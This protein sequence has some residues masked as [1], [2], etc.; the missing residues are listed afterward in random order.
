MDTT[1]T[2]GNVLT[3]V[4]MILMWAGGAVGVY[5]KLN[6][7]ISDIYSSQEGLGR[8]TE[9]NE[10]L[11]GELFL[12]RDQLHDLVISIKSDVAIIMAAIK[13]MEK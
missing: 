4:G 11:I 10:K 6:G 9:K 13:R 3:I 7:K 5:V 8:R 12:K 1:F 2:V